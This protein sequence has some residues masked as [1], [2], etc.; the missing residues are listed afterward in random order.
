MS[1]SEGTAGTSVTQTQIQPIG[2]SGPVDGKSNAGPLRAQCWIAEE[3]EDDV[4]TFT[5]DV[6]LVLSRFMQL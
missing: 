3:I 6:K 4:F 5:L 1:M 2:Q